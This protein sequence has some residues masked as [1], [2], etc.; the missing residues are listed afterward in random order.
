MTFVCV[1]CARDLELT[2]FYRSPS[3]KDKRD[4]TCKACRGAAAAARREASVDA[5]KRA[6]WLATREA[7]ERAAMN[8]R[9][10]DPVVQAWLC[11][12]A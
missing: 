4:K 5:E 8:I 2:D 9:R 10:G 3:T 11:R 6:R 7:N 12:P 1:K